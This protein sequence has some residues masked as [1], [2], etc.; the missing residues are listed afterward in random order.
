MCTALN[1]L[2]WVWSFAMLRMNTTHTNTVHPAKI[3]RNH[4][5]RE[6]TRPKVPELRRAHP[7]AAPIR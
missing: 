6:V 1:P 4:A 2:E 3:R 5:A 7:L